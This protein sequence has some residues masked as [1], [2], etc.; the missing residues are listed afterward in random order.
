MGIPSGNMQRNCSYITV[1]KLSP[2]TGEVD[3]GI[4]LDASRFGDL[5]TN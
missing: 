4:G 3:K 1:E 2:I 5:M